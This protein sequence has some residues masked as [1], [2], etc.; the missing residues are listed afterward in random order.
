[1]FVFDSPADALDFLRSLNGFD[2]ARYVFRGEPQGYPLRLPT[3]ARG[4]ADYYARQSNYVHYLARHIYEFEL[5]DKLRHS[6]CG[7]I[8]DGRLL[9]FPDLIGRSGGE[10]YAQLVWHLSGFLQHYGLT[11]NWLDLTFEPRVALFF[12]SWLEASKSYA[13]SGLGYIYYTQI[14]RIPESCWPLVD[15]HSTSELFARLL[16]LTA[17]RSRAQS[18]CA[19]RFSP[20]LD[21]VQEAASEFDCIAFRRDS[22][23]RLVDSKTFFP[24]ETVT[25]WLD[26]F[27]ASRQ[28]WWDEIQ[29]SVRENDEPNEALQPRRTAYLYD[30]RKR[31]GNKWRNKSQP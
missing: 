24:R 19:L 16:G 30:S 27:V 10:G 3:A 8:L 2:K 23:V 6:S 9:E 13:D 31:R 4:R 18:A 11:T 20:H 26:R 14:Y 5:A 17:E 22:S 28:E 29:R 15:L 1:M 21:V 12:A 7:P 25:T